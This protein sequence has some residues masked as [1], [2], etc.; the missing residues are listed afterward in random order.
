MTTVG[1]TASFTAVLAP[2][3]PALQLIT[4][5]A[6]SA[7][8]NTSAFSATRAVSTADSDGDGIPDSYEMA[9]GL[10]PA[11]N[12][13]GGDR[14][15]DGLTNLGEFLAGTDPLL[16]ANVLRINAVTASGPDI[17]VTFPTVA[18]KIYRLETRDS[19]T[20]GAWIPLIEQFTGTGSPLTISDPG[21]AALGSRFYRASVL[22]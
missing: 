15:D 6:T 20:T 2:A 14:D 9:H 4:A 12:D 21:A 3:V 11:V 22:P 1:G 13:A 17:A 16:S 5:T 18:G 19:F 7:A 10:N 8:G